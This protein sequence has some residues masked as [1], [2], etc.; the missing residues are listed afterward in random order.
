MTCGT[1]RCRLHF[2]SGKTGSAPSPTPASECNG[3]WERQVSGNGRHA[4]GVPHGQAC[5][6]QDRRR[7]RA[8]GKYKGLATCIANPLI[9]LAPRPGL[10]PGT[11]GLTVG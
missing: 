4:A 3:L 2:R 5:A 8:A 10:E 7:T 9:F 11:Y 1:C 6:S